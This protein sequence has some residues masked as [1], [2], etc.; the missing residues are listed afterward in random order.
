MTTPLHASRHTGGLTVL[1]PALP[2]ELCGVGDYI[3]QLW[4]HVHDRIDEGLSFD[5]TKGWHFMTV[6]GSEK[7]RAA[8]PLAD[9]Q[10]LPLTADGLINRLESC[11][12]TCVFL[13]YVGQ[14]YEPH[15]V[16]TFLAD[17]LAEWK[18]HD[19]SRRILTMFHEVYPD[20]VGPPWKSTFW[21]GPRQKSTAKRLLSLSDVAVT[22]NQYYRELLMA[23][24]TGRDIQVIPFGSTLV[25]SQFVAFNRK[26]LL[27]FG[28]ERQKVLKRNEA[29]LKT[30]AK[31]QLIE[32]IVLAGRNPGGSGEKEQ[33]LLS[34]LLPSIEVMTA[35]EF[36]S[37]DI[38]A[39]V[40]S[41]GL[42]LMDMHSALLQKSSRFQLA[43]ALGQ[44]AIAQHSWEP[45]CPLKNGENFLSYA[46]GDCEKIVQQLR[47]QELVEKISAN[48]RHL[49][50]E[51][52]SWRRIA[53]SWREV[54]SSI[55]A[56]FTKQVA[57]SDGDS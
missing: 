19:R 22:S 32:T 40:R 16:P 57:F 14:G 20:W 54:I 10:E 17:G 44:V 35:F 53:A 5:A 15:G 50:E 46:S 45:G 11:G 13:Q 1:L 12:V 4:R 9:I 26:K 6:R 24:G 51:Y 7:S 28:L 21:F 48:A 52:F 8:F 43:C 18:Q 31:E 23:L 39:A 33:Q 55:N 25:V 42:S 29:L 36:L 56:D 41:C 49:S 47:S 2:P 38:P 37:E 30:L 27:V 3:A 34:K